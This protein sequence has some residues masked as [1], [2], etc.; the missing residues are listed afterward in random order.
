M[1]TRHPEPEPG[2]LHVKGSQTIGNA[3]K[4]GECLYPKFMDMRIADAKRLQHLRMTLWSALLTVPGDTAA[5]PLHFAFKV[6]VR[7]SSRVVDC[8]A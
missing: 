2:N 5:R 1:S 6:S 7:I 8:I 3:Q 4:E